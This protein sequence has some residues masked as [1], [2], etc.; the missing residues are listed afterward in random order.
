MA[1]EL[2]LIRFNVVNF[3]S[4]LMNS[5]P[6]QPI[7]TLLIKLV[8]SIIEAEPTPDVEQKKRV[9]W[10]YENTHKNVNENLSIIELAVFKNLNKGLNR[11]L[12]IGDKTYSLTELYQYLDEVSKELSTIVIM[13]A[14]KYSIDIPMLQMSGQG[15]QAIDLNG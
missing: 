13:I 3:F 1:D 7:S 11:E 4:L 5:R 2:S 14:K 12:E 10:I 15:S 6:F 9:R 8:E